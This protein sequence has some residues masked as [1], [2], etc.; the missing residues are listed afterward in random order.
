MNQPFV[1]FFTRA[2][3]RPVMI[4]ALIEAVLK[5]TDQDL[6]QIFLPDRAGGVHPEGPVLW[7]NNQIPKHKHRVDGQYVYFL[8]DDGLLLREDFVEKVKDIAQR[9]IY[10]HV[11]L[12]KSICNKDAGS[13]HVLPLVWD[14]AW[15]QGERPA[16]WAGHGYNYVVRTDYWK[17]KVD[18]YSGK[19]RGGDAHFGNA[20]I[21]DKSA[22]IVR[23]DI[24]AAMSMQ[25]GSGVKFEPCGK[26]WWEN[27]AGKYGIEHL[28][29]DDWRLRL[30]QK[31]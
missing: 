12:V 17:A 27:V 23:L 31:L 8:D 21:S 9:Y 11:I 20:L 30:W 15:G 7:A 26:R 6:E 1:T 28:G 3:K 13:L 4:G 16:K 14:C 19:R 10:P 22:K 29:G 2:C 25:R 18:A 24:I 5:Q